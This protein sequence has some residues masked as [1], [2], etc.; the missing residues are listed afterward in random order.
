MDKTSKKIIHYLKSKEC[1][2][3]YICR[4]DNE[5]NELA[6]S[7]C[8]PVEDLRAAVRW[9]ESQGILEYQ[10]YNGGKICGFHL[11]HIGVNWNYFRRKQLIEYIE[12]KWIDFFSLLASIAAL[13]ISVIALVSK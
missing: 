7:L 13:L 5:F 2:S 6:E 4:F 10:C 9:L 3:N 11:S 1:G 8:I 12:E